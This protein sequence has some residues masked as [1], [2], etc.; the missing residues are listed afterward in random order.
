MTKNHQ[1]EE[2]DLGVLFNGI[3]RITKRIMILIFRFIQFCIRSWI[4]ILAL[5]I[6][7]IVAGYLWQKNHKGKQE[8]ALIIRTNFQSSTYVYSAI[9]Q[10][11]E[12]LYNK[13]AVEDFPEISKIE[14]E[15]VIN[16]EELFEDFENEMVV[17]D[18]V[19]IFQDKKGPYSP[20]AFVPR[21]KFH[22]IEVIFTQDANQQSITRLIDYLGKNSLL[23]EIKKVGL[24]NLEQR[25]VDN[26]MMVDQ[27]DKFLSRISSADAINNASLTILQGGGAMPLDRVLE[28][29]KELLEENDEIRE[30][31]LAQQELVVLINKPRMLVYNSFLA[32]KIIMLPLLLLFLFFLL[33]FFRYI[34]QKSKKMA[35]H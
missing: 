35:N 2:V 23:E 11:N 9:E 16:V 14:I 30:N 32:N 3:K 15:P 13:K 28:F 26:E 25:L 27:I 18:L 24:Q 21:Y 22:K 19:E 33:S 10:L 29:K 7:G 31:I 34:Y 8:T 12:R 4:T 5:L 6:I 20:E 17:I 1:S